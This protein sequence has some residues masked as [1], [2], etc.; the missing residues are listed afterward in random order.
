MSGQDGGVL[1][2][3]DGAGVHLA[4]LVGRKGET[5][6]VL[7]GHGEADLLEVEDDFGHILD[8]PRN[9]RELVL[10]AL[11]AGGDDGRALQGGQQG[12]AQ[13]VAERRAES[14]LQGLAHEPADG[15]GRDG[16][17]FELFR[18]DQFGPVAGVDEPLAVANQHGVPLC[19][20]YF[21][22]YLE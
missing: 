9:G 10:H 17:A 11:D 14:A 5:L 15:I 4:L 21:A 19:K 2:A 3:L 1:V 18:L 12:P 22:D 13:S 8:D 7:G 6:R 16:V 20:A